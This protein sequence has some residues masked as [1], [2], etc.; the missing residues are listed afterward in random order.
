MNKKQI[1]VTWL[2]GILI[3]VLAWFP[4]KMKVNYKGEIVLRMCSFSK[5]Y[6]YWN[7]EPNIKIDWETWFRYVI[8]LVMGGSLLIY[9]LRSKKK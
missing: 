4:P 1:V 5:D 9:T 6:F 7:P 2:I 8:S 3:V